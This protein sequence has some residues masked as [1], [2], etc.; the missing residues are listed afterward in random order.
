[1]YKRGGWMAQ[2]NKL[3]RHHDIREEIYHMGQGRTTPISMTHVYGHNR[4]VYNEADTLAK[5]G[6]A[7]STSR[8]VSGTCRRVF[9]RRPDESKPGVGESSDRPSASVTPQYT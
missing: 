7:L 3:V 8:G 6:V 9:E 1:M 4:L 5:V 2:G